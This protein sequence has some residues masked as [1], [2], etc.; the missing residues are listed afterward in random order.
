MTEQ[1]TSEASP[2]R[3]SWLMVLPAIVFLFLDPYKRNPFVRFHSVQC[4]LFWLAG[5]LVAV[6]LRLA[7]LGLLF[8]PAVGPLLAVL[9]TAIVALAAVIGWI[10]LIVKAFQG[11][12][13]RLPVIGQLAEQYSERGMDAE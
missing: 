4:L 12:R 13:F 1:V 2:Q 5:V 9:L 7:V 3:R 10:V 8:I 11:E 6:L